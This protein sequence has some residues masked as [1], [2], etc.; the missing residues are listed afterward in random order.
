MEEVGLKRPFRDTEEESVVELARLKA[1]RRRKRKLPQ[2]QRSLSIILASMQGQ[3]VVVEL[4]DDSEVRGIIESVL[5]SMD[6]CLINATH[7]LASGST[8]QHESIEVKGGK[9]RYVHMSPKVRVASVVSSYVG[10]L[11]FINRAAPKI[12]DDKRRPAIKEDFVFEMPGGARG[13]S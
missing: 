6:V 12:S 13:E 10:K 2:I 8:S 9:I 1:L 5:P 11:A 7:T 3:E 4:K